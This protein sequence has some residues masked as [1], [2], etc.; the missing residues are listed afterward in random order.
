MYLVGH[1]LQTSY[2]DSFLAY[3]I[4]HSPP[5]TA[6]VTNEWSYTSMTPVCLLGMDRDNLLLTQYN[7]QEDI[8]DSVVTRNYYRSIHFNTI[9]IYV[10]IVNIGWQPM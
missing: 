10:N 6:E 1:Q 8:P 7:I 9:N 3:E 2:H 4:D 5:S